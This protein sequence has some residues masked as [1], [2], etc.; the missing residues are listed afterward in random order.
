MG[1]CCLNAALAK[2]DSVV[3]SEEVLRVAVLI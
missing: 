2:C 3:L 1:V